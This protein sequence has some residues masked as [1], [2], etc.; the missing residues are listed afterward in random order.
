MLKQLLIEEQQHLEQEKQEL[1]AQKDFDRAHF[2]Q[3]EI[4]IVQVQYMLGWLAA[5]ST[6]AQ[7]HGPTSPPRT[8]HSTSCRNWAVRN[9]TTGT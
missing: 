3:L 8:S 4:M 2:Y 6:R 1:L 9:A 7:H 5:T